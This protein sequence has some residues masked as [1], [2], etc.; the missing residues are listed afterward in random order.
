MSYDVFISYRRSTGADDARLLQQAFKARG[1]EVFFDYDSLR[2]GKFDEKIY[3]A[4]DEAP[5]FVLM[6]MAHSLDRCVQEGDWVRMEIERALAKERHVVPV[7]P[8]SQ[9]WSVPDGLPESLRGIPF[10]QA[11]ELNKTQLFEESIDKIVENRFPEGL[12]GK[13]RKAGDAVSTEGR[14]SEVFVGREN[15]LTRLHELLAAGKFPVVTGAGGD[16]KVG[17]GKAI[18]RTLPG[19][20]SR[21]TTP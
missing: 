7:A 20:V 5:V 2:D 18:H 21:R 14:A 17:T 11:S 4:I 1:F 15:E 3:E 13:C 12:K 6:L 8:T 16:G 19:R 9:S 10:E